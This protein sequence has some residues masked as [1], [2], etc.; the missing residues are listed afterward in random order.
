MGAK[1]AVRQAKASRLAAL[2]R[3][4]QILRGQVEFIAEMAGLSPHLAT[5]R[6]RADL[7]NPG[8][9]VPDPNQEPAPE[10]TAE[11]LMPDTEGDASRPGAEGGSLDR[12]PAEQVTTALTPGVEIPTPPASNLISVTAPIQGTN[13]A[14]D[15]GVPIPQRRIE[16]DV[17]IDPDPLKASGPGIGGQGNDGTG[18]PWVISARETQKTAAR[19]PTADEAAQLRTMA[20]MRLA[21]L[22]VTAGISRGD[23]LALSQEIFA[24]RAQTRDIEHEIAVLNQVAA[25]R[26]PAAPR[27]MQRQASRPVPSLASAPSLAPA[28]ASVGGFQDD[29]CSD[30]F[31][32]FGE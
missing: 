1:K 25:A 30:I 27:P 23:D 4:N 21:R 12:V 24:S 9:P 7:G 6:S 11:V 16:T 8:S 17:R 29:D 13:P 14:Q 2:T 32:S 31:D 5:I 3:E 28:Y 26:P 18:F 20:S 22:R 10:S 15:G 19:Q